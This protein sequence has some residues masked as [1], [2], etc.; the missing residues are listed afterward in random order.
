MHTGDVL[1]GVAASQSLHLNI[2][3]ALFNLA[4][5]T[6]EMESYLSQKVNA[7]DCRIKK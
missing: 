5:E 2:G 3:M 6:M 7:A 1:Y 4:K